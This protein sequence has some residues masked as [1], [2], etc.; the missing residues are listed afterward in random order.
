M[1]E[2]SVVGAYGDVVVPTRMPDVDGVRAMMAPLECH[3]ALKGP[4]RL[5]P[6]SMPCCPNFPA[7]CGRS[8]LRPTGSEDD[9]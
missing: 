1:P 4:K 5:T 6:D 9:S 3:A 8:V 2:A 7:H